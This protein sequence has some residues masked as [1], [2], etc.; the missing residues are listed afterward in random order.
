MFV[1]QKLNPPPADPMQAKVFLLMP[2]MFTYM[3]AAFPAGLVIYW[4]WN[5]ILTIAQQW[6]IMHLAEKQKIRE[7]EQIKSR[8][9]RA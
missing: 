6:T 7:L 4:T 1:Q 9:K 8:K 5:N 3:L 2:I